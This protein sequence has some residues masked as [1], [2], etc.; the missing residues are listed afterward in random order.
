M[1][2]PQRLVARFDLI[3]ESVA[4]GLLHYFGVNWPPVPILQML[5]YPPA[6]LQRNLGVSLALPYAEA[7]YIRLLS[8]RG[9]V[10]V[11]PA[12]SKVR[13]RFVAA[14]EVLRGLADLPGG[15]ALELEQL[16]RQQPD[17]A[18]Y[19]ARCLLMPSDFLPL[20]WANM[21]VEALAELFDVSIEIAVMRR[22][23]LSG[24]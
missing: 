14:R 7:T 5:E 6:S 11:N 21:P 13:Q 8:G 23:E 18:D 10:F 1:S 2:G 9:V 15:R 3:L 12:L 20:H 22:A 19:F 16:T 17:A 24:A 4:Y